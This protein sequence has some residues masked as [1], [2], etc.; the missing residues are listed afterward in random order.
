MGR[1]IINITTSALVKCLRGEMRL[2]RFPSD[3]VIEAVKMDF[4]KS[5]DIVQLRVSS[6]KFRHVPDFSVIDSEMRGTVEIGGVAC[7]E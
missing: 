7:E 1:K 4:T 6:D 2:S 3:A 5:T